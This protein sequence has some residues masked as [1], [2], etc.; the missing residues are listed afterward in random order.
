MKSRA[1]D[2]EKIRESGKKRGKDGKIFLYGTH[3]LFCPILRASWTHACGESVC[4][5]QMRC[6]L[7]IHRTAHITGWFVRGGV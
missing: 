2:K 3:C 1:G 6:L 4:V 7:S 5:I